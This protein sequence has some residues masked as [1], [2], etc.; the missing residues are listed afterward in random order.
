MFTAATGAVLENPAWFGFLFLLLLMCARPHVHRMTVIWLSDSNK[1]KEKN[2]RGALR[3]SACDCCKIR[4]SHIQ[5]PTLT[6]H[7]LPTY[8]V[9]L[10][11]YI[12]PSKCAWNEYN[13]WVDPGSLDVGRFQ[14]KHIDQRIWSPSSLCQS[15]GVSKVKQAT[16]WWRRVRGWEGRRVQPTGV[17]GHQH[18]RVAE[19]AAAKDRERSIIIK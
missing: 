16:G 7:N 14:C 1:R 5:G 10:Q 8:Y 4:F 15:N 18:K 11:S 12:K 3:D 17:Y 19:C 13:C 2:R 9:W 6:I